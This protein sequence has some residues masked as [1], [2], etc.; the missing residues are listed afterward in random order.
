MYMYACKKIFYV[1]MFSSHFLSPS[2]F[3]LLSLPPSL[4]PSSSL[5][6]IQ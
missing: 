6:S 4:P 5:L 1:N 3:P 2:P